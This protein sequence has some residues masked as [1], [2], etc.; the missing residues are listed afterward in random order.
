ML[1]LTSFVIFGKFQPV[2]DLDSLSIKWK[3]KYIIFSIVLRIWD[4][5]CNT[6]GWHI[7]IMKSSQMV[8]QAPL[9]CLHGQGTQSFQG[10]PLHL[11]AE[12]TARNVLCL[13]R[14]LFLPW[15]LPPSTKTTQ[16]KVNHSLVCQ[17]FG[18]LKIALILWDSSTSFFYSE[19]LTI[20]IAFISKTSALSLCS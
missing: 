4:A 15:V 18:H 12:L 19:S 3:S 17:F 5:L 9:G 13:K 10:S 7:V 6:H 20:L 11:C 14:N 1:L 16:N 2:W 8:I